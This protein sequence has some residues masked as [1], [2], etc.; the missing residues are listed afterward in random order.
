MSKITRPRLTG[1]L[2]CLLVVPS[3]VAVQAVTDAGP[4]AIAVQQQGTPWVVSLGDSFISGEAGRWAGS[5]LSGPTAADA[6]GA[7]SYNDQISSPGESI[8]GCHRSTSAEIYFGAGTRGHNLACSGAKVRTT[9]GVTG[10]FKPGLDFA[11]TPAGRG[12]AAELTDFARTHP[13]KMVVVSIGGNDFNFFNTIA[14][15]G[16]DYANSL[17][18]TP[19]YCRDEPAILASFTPSAAA[20]ASSA[21]QG[22]LENVQQAMRLAGYQDQN[23]TLV[24]QT[25]P[26][27]LPATNRIRYP[28]LD[29]SRLA[30]GGC[31]FWDRDIQW[32]NQVAVPTINSAVV[33][34]FNAAAIPGSKLLQLESALEGR[35]LCATGLSRYGERGLTSWTD[36]KAVNQTEWVNPVRLGPLPYLYQESLHPN[37]WAQLAFRSCLRQIWNQGQV[38]AGQCVRVDSGLSSRGEPMMGLN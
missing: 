8:P 2:R 20:A 25:Y 3:L 24:V 35:K 9:T 37:Y 38:R 17:G 29:G 36:R 7:D 28:E 19:Q 21:I 4:A 31:G 6:L 32:S 14:R 18:Q 1:L 15:C 5:S 12:Q 30:V 16:F 27:I 26:N 34:A 10:D 23:W 11:N 22:G 33:A 13:V